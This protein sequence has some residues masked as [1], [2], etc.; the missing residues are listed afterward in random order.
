MAW[1]A[2]ARLNLVVRPLSAAL[3]I[4]QIG[5]AVG[6]VTAAALALAG[7]GPVKMLDLL[8]SRPLVLFGAVALLALLVAGATLLATLPTV[9]TIV[10]GIP[11][12]CKRL[13]FLACRG[14]TRLSRQVGR[15][16]LLVASDFRAVQ[17]PH[18]SQKDVI[19]RIYAG[20]RSAGTSGYDVIV[21]PSGFGKT[22]CATLLAEALIRDKD[23]CLLADRCL[24]YDLARG[25]GIH[26]LFI[27]RLGGLAHSGALVIVDNFH[28]ATPAI[29]EET[30]ARLLGLAQPAAERHVLLL[31]QPPGAWRL[32][33]QSEIKLL[34]EARRRGRLY[35][36]RGL[37]QSEAEQALLSP[38]ARRRMQFLAPAIGRSWASIAEIHSVQMDLYAPE[39]ER[40]VA[41]R[42]SEYLYPAQTVPPE[43]DSN[44]P[45]PEVIATATALA[46][47]HGAF[48][49]RSFRGAYTAVLGRAGPG[50]WPAM[51]RARLWLRRLARIGLFP[52]TSLPGRL[53]VLHETLAEHFRDHLGARDARFETAFRRA[54]TWRLD[55]D[56][57]GRAP[58]TQWL[59]AADLRDSARLTAWFD[60]AMTEGNL[61][62][63][64]RRLGAN[65]PYLGD[66]AAEYQLGVI[67]DKHG[68][69]AEAREHLA[70][71]IAL[72][73]EGAFSE[74]AE[75]A[76]IEAAHGPES[77]RTAA[78]L[79]A[80][81]RQEIRLS[82]AYWR[83]HL[84]AH[85]GVFDP[86]GLT[87]LA[88]DLT[89][90][91]DPALIPKSFILAR[92]AAR[93]YF[94]ACRHVFLRR[95]DVAQRLRKLASLPILDVLRV[96]DPSYRASSLL[97]GPAHLLAFVALP[98]RAVFGRTPEPRDL[99]GTMLDGDD[100]EPLC[101]QVEAAYKSA[102]DEFAVFGNRSQ[103]YLKAD[104][105]NARLQNPATNPLDVRLA[106]SDYSDF[107]GRAGFD[108]IASYPE[109]YGLRLELKARQ[110]ALS[111]A[112][113]RSRHFDSADDHERQARHHLSR[114]KRMDDACGNRYGQWRGRLYE[115][116]FEAISGPPAAGRGAFV[117]ALGQLAGD[118]RAGGYMGDADYVARFL[119]RGDFSLGQIFNALLYHPFVHQ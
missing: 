95:E 30:T 57:A 13:V 9:R 114:M 107:I 98:E 44:Q 8:R 25:A 93:V 67:L 5:I 102:Q 100:L 37:S 19:D 18:P 11:S 43:W 54:L 50:A 119:D 39:R 71:A 14:S 35:E 16:C 65:L 75:L 90:A 92:L 24:Y 10:G 3:Q 20:I 86:D 113:D 2:G 82:A 89:E 38:D 32:Q 63:M 61:G 78:R 101:R 77:V 17:L 56:L 23:L 109:A 68:R 103:L 12:R 60:G 51:F 62:A 29:V 36:I 52:R 53:Y 27:R 80:S 85:G 76:L 91:I 108:D 84:D 83:Y 48:S 6:V 46:L 110:W 81:S 72:G 112:V 41:G 4:A 96:C 70:R 55:V 105:L 87:A 94:D 115:T 69:F 79:G 47:H 42:I 74:S 66:A 49:E 1:D 118:A 73:G 88:A 33:G 111:G 64:A 26:D 21:A 34:T 97:Y 7:S 45:L 116:L 104:I 117:S 40:D 28:L 59:G 22:R 31:A 99:L 106:L 58:A 15:L